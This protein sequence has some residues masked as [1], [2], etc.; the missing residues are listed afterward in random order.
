[1]CLWLFITPA[2]WYWVYICS[3]Q[4]HHRS[5]VDLLECCIALTDS[6]VIDCANMHEANSIFRCM[7]SI[8]CEYFLCELL[9]THRLTL[10]ETGCFCRGSALTYSMHTWPIDSLGF[11][12][13]IDPQVGDKWK[14]LLTGR[15]CVSTDADAWV[16]VQECG[17]RLEGNTAFFLKKLPDLFYGWW[18]HQSNLSLHCVQLVWDVTWQRM[19][20]PAVILII[21]F[22]MQYQNR[23]QNQNPLY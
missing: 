20:H 1:M 13:I 18:K 23:N 22:I 5:K 2:L 9:V 19:I 15:V 10:E 12:V 14:E 21:P 3:C 6:T 8:M 11:T 17:T 16:I 7:H 4:L